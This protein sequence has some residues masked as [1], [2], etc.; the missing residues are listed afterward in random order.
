[1][2]EFQQAFDWCGLQRHLKIL[3]IF[4]RL[5]FR[6]NKSNYL[7][8]LPLTFQYVMACAEAYE[9]FSAFAQ[10]LNVRVKNSFM[11]QRK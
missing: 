11:S 2:P 9:E 7:H 4:C 10:W 8:D 3:G 6:D 5:H 1:M